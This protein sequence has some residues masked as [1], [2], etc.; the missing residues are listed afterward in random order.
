MDIYIH[1]TNR[2]IY[3][4]CIFA[5]LAALGAAVA[6]VIPKP[7]LGNYDSEISHVSPVV[8]VIIIFVMNAI[9]FSIRKKP[10]DKITK[11]HILALIGAGIAEASGTILYYEGLRRTLASDAS[12]ISNS[13]ILFGVI[14]AMIL[15]HELIKRKE[16]FPIFLILVGSIVIPI[17]IEFEKNSFSVIDITSEGNML[18]IIS[19][20]LFATGA[21]L[22]RYVLRKNHDGFSK[23]MRISFT[24]G[25]LFCILVLL[26][27]EDWQSIQ[28]PTYVDIPAILLSGIFGMGLSSLFFVMALVKIGATR[29]ILLYSSSPVFA[30]IFAAIYLSEE[31]QIYDIMSLSLIIVGVILLKNKI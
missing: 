25:A 14:L 9:I 23:I 8:F 21:I 10:S 2:D 27:F 6:D 17:G 3:L 30:V 29:T 19:S 12:I 28:I 13:E 16:I 26:F 24:S 31:I 11:N 20:V 15:F 1:K 22:Y 7:I 4:G 18:I 5:L